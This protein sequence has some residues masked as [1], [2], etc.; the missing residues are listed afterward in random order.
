MTRRVCT[1]K[2]LWVALLALVIMLPACRSNTTIRRQS[3]ECFDLPDAS[4]RV[5]SYT[6]LLFKP[7]GHE[8]PERR[9]PL[10]LYMPG[11]LSFGHDV[12]KLIDDDPPEEIEGGRRLPMVVMTPL[13]PTFL[14]RWSPETTLSMIDYAI[15]H[16]RV[17]PNRVYVSGVS[18]GAVGAWDLAKA[19]PHRVAAIVPVSS[20]GS[21]AGVGRM[22][23]VPVWAFHGSFDVVV[24]SLRQKRLVDAHRACG[25][26]A[27]WT[28]IPGGHQVWQKVYC[29]DD[30][31]AW[32]LAQ[33]SAGNWTKSPARTR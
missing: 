28:V 6:Y 12:Q 23:H 20:W 17:D 33:S 22:S 29:R 31:Y 19:Y 4:G 26:T 13:A 24:P 27:R 1:S 10:L 3:T 15:Q 21:T 14:E 18:I 32:M 9:W 5:Q 16:Y 11:I 30:L 25:G 2:T 7:P 8:D